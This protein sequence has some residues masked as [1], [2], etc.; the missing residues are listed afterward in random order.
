MRKSLWKFLGILVCLC[1][2]LVMT[3]CGNAFK[4]EGT[5]SIDVSEMVVAA[6]KASRDAG[7][8]VSEQEQEIA[9]SKDDITGDYDNDPEEDYDDDD[10]EDED[11]DEQA[12]EYDLINDA[13]VMNVKIEVSLTSDGSV[14]KTNKREYQISL[15]KFEEEIAGDKDIDFIKLFGISDSV[16]T[17]KNI[18]IGSV[19]NAHVEMES[20]VG[21]NNKEALKAQLK[22]YLSEN[23]MMGEITDD[24]LDT[25]IDSYIE[26]EIKETYGVVK[27]SGDST[28]PLVV[29]ANSKSNVIT[30][31][32]TF[33]EE[34][35]DSEQILRIQLRFN[36]GDGNYVSKSGFPDVEIDISD[37][38]DI[39]SIIQELVETIDNAGYET[40]DE[41]LNDWL[42]FNFG[43][44]ISAGR[45]VV[46]LYLDK[47]KMPVPISLKISNLPAEDEDADNVLISVCTT[48]VDKTVFNNFVSVF[49]NTNKTESEKIEYLAEL[50]DSESACKALS[51]TGKN[52]GLTVTQKDSG[53]EA[54]AD[55][56]YYVD[57]DSSFG[58]SIGDEVGVITITYYGAARGFYKY[59]YIGYSS[60][61]ITLDSQ[62]NQVAIT[63]KHSN[64]FPTKVGLYDND[65]PVYDD[66]DELISF[67]V[68]VPESYKSS[69]SGE[70]VKQLFS[71]QPIVQSYIKDGY[72][73]MSLHCSSFENNGIDNSELKLNKE[74][75]TN[76]VLSIVYKN[77]TDETVLETIECDPSSSST[78]FEKAFVD[79]YKTLIH[80][81]YN[82][83]QSELNAYMANIEGME[84]F[85]FYICK[86][87]D[88]V[89]YFD[90]IVK[91]PV[92]EFSGNITNDTSLQGDYKFIT[93]TDYTYEIV[94]KEQN[95]QTTVIST[96]TWDSVYDYQEHGF[97]DNKYELCET[98]YYNFQTSTLVSI[99]GISTQTVVIDVNPFSFI[100]GSGGKFTFG[101]QSQQ[102]TES[103]SIS[104]DVDLN[105]PT[106]TLSVIAEVDED[107]IV[108]LIAED[109]ANTDYKEYTWRIDGKDLGLGENQ[110]EFFFDAINDLHYESGDV[111]S[112][113]LMATDENDRVHSCTVQV[114]LQ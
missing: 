61:T 48:L 20:S 17:F 101:T 85:F 112:I 13:L 93:Y 7:T 31:K 83:S 30:V 86:N 28:V 59:P 25:F 49:E 26:R 56:I 2:T 95:N 78:V 39:D 18:P 19:V 113:L 90:S 108:T 84:E 16:L 114:E 82:V 3:G 75:S 99:T 70:I 73:I 5:V 91:L 67:Y 89:L 66:N 43:E 27:G 6:L 88:T 110:A 64:Y 45:N 77:G 71:N 79:T 102:E 100:S 74:K 55:V 60:N 98:A 103:T 53:L 40:A 96:G 9:D 63:A 65:S 87:G 32:L 47:C 33:E 12:S 52:N 35:D 42:D 97:N 44:L 68:A 51:R 11:D 58:K 62:S 8:V 10:D 50:L 21:V 80:N 109:S 36:D 57:S 38:D 106:E 111:I 54:V 23:P 14:N 94:R 4:D 1:F 92:N 37:P 81:G 29:T 69:G 107:G 41:S 22:E 105:I 34:S 24:R 15:D 72:E 104:V 76:P 46:T